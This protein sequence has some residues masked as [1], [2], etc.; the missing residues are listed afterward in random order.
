MEE[1]ERVIFA[2]DMA[3]KDSRDFSSAVV[4]LHYND[5]NHIIYNT[6]K[7]EEVN[8]LN[9]VINR[10]NKKEL[11]LNTLFKKNVDIRQLRHYIETYKEEGDER[12]LKVYNDFQNTEAELTLEEYYAIKDLM[13]NKYND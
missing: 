2:V 4:V 9:T 1:K 6:I 8:A 7:D 12:I 5:C 13:L 11:V 3:S 10:I